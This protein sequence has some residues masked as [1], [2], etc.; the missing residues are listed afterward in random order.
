VAEKPIKFEFVAEVAQYL[1]E[2]KK[3]EVS[4]EDI[5]D[6][7]LHVSNESGDLERKLARAMREAEKDTE[8][9][10]RV[11]DELPK[12]TRKA[13]QAA[14]DDFKKI[15]DDARDAGREVGDEFRQNLG[16]SLSSGSMEDLV[17]DTLGGIVGSMKGPLGLAAA[18][19]AGVGALI[20]N[21][22]KEEWQ[23][24]VEAMGT[25]AQSL[26]EKQLEVGRQFL[27][28]QERLEVMRDIIKENP[29]LWG[30]IREQAESLGY[31]LEDVASAMLGGTAEADAFKKKLQDAVKEGTTLE[32]GTGRISL[33]GPA[34]QALQLLQLMQQASGATEDANVEFLNM[35][36]LLGV[37]AANAKAIQDALRNA[38]DYAAG[39]G[40]RAPLVGL[41]QWEKV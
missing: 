10:K 18:G 11:L 8:S 29:D 23:A 35:Q 34:S 12:S 2:T 17:S 39:I 25:M 40:G 26:V 30:K 22:L 19:V 31:T 37:S 3:M 5:A 28:Q 1:R 33:T 20:F 15:G 32:Q 36:S 4:T 14:D 9:L 24:T 16:E 38:R 41:G 27:F 21:K 7:L 13:A 6:A